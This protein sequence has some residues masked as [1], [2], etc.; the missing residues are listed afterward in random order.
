MA[1]IN[2]HQLSQMDPRDSFVRRAV[3]EVCHV[4]HGQSRRSNVDR[5]KYCQLSSTD[6]GRVH[7]TERPALW[8]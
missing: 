5:R 8:S 6:N 3:A 4:L 1:K 7:H 2:K